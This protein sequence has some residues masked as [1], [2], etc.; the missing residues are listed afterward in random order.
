LASEGPTPPS[1]FSARHEFAPR[2]PRMGHA[3]GQ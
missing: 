3:A 2:R 1:S